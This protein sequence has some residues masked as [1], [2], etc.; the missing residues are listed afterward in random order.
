MTI[1][2]TTTTS[3]AKCFC[4]FLLLLG[5]AIGYR[6]KPFGVKRFLYT[7]RQPKLEAAAEL[8]AEF[9]ES[10]VLFR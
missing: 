10:C 2:L 1:F 7:G 3:R 4:I 9:G 5:R 8:K 6:L